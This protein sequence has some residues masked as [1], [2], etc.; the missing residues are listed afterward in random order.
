MLSFLRI[1]P[2]LLKYSLPFLQLSYC[3]R[4]T[5]LPFNDNP[6]W[7]RTVFAGQILHSY[8]AKTGAGN[9]IKE[10]HSA[11]YIPIRISR[12]YLWKFFLVKFLSILC[13]RFADAYNT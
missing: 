11:S 13:R 3:K 5:H 8:T 4:K 2:E 7:N 6:R 12:Q 9:V 1:F 10:N